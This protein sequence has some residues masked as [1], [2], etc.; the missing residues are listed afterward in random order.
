MG[1]KT[2][3][4]V[5]PFAP[6]DMETV[7]RAAEVNKPRRPAVS[8]DPLYETDRYRLVTPLAPKPKKLDETVIQIPVAE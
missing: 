2:I 8:R 3:Q 7:K 4:P 6:L 5:P 1:E